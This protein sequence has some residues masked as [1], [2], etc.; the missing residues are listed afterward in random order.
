MMHLIGV[1]NY[2]GKS[3]KKIEGV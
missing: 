3:N 2:Y 1:T